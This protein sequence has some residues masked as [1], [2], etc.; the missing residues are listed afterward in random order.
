MN[1]TVT[2]FEQAELALAAYYNLAPDMTRA[3]YEAALRGDGDGMSAAQASAFAAKWNVVD[4]YSDITS[5]ASATVFQAVSGGPKYLAIR[6]TDFGL[7]FVVDYFIFNGVP[8]LLNPQYQSLKIQVQAWLADPDVLQGQTFT[9]AGHSLGGYLAAAGNNRGQT[10]VSSNTSSD[11]NTRR[12]PCPVVP[13]CRYP[14]SRSILSSAAITG[15]PA[16][17]PTKITA[18]IWTGWLSTPTKQAAKFMP[19]C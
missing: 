6:G 13:A 9:A 7:D 12:R 4:Q 16:S 3:A 2:Y 5:G 14:M 8:S 17:L 10:T 19:M 11:M 18:S 15:R 1:S